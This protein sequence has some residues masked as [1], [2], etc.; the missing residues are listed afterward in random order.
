MAI[1]LLSRE[2]IKVSQQSPS[3]TGEGKE[4]RSSITCVDFRLI[5]CKQTCLK[6]R[7]EQKR[8]HLRN[9]MVLVLS[10]LLFSSSSWVEPVGLQSRYH[11]SNREVA[12]LVRCWTP[13]GLQFS[14]PEGG[15]PG[16]ECG[17]YPNINCL[18]GAITDQPCKPR[19]WSSCS[20]WRPSLS[21]SSF[22]CLRPSGAAALGQKDTPP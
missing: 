6:E 21:P 18:P 12:D 16:S 20:A 13:R 7:K 1:A 17:S 19:S 3:K 2:K 22:C 11:A 10:L 14:V 15:L 8:T 5:T 4:A 9:L